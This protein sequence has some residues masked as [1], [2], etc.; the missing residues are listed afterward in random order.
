MI[1]LKNKKIL[2]TGGAGFLGAYVFKTLIKRGV[3]KE[4]IF[5]PRSNEYDLRKRGVCDKL[6]SN[7]DV[8]IHLAALVGGI[9]FNQKNPAS[10]FYDNASMALNLID[11]AHKNGVEKF[12]GI[13]SVCSYPKFAKIPF[14]ETDLWSGY[15]E[16]TSASYGLAKKMMLVQSQAYYK[17][18]GFNAVHL[19]MINLYGP[20][21]NF[22][23]Q[24][25][26]VIPA[27]IK[28]IGEAKNNKLSFV[29]MW[30]SGRATRE[31][32]YA[33]DAAEGIVL[34]AEKYNKPDPVNIGCNTEISI[35]KLVNLICKI[36]KYKGEV[37]WDTS[38][39]DGQPRRMLNADLAKK[40]F[41]FTS[42]ISLNDG[43]KKTIDWYVK[44]KL[45]V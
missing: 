9:S 45:L 28:K 12:V 42:K 3:K 20:G 14:I 10:I 2:L 27:L 31:F 33:E 6:V 22:N 1:D 11:S 35:K 29:E 25:S 18:Y 13:G 44:F 43:L 32:L 30:G 23:P 37:R 5:I 36:I 21:D 17:Q 15:P 7:K 8:I 34:A 40:A 41:G 16:E 4:N 26:H 38:K 39:P 24:S 19:L